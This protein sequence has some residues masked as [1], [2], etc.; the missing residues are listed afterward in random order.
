[1]KYAVFTSSIGNI[2]MA[3]SKHII[4]VIAVFAMTSVF[5]HLNAQQTALSPVLTDY[6]NLKDALV[7]SDSKAAAEKAATLVKEINSVDMGAIPAKDH[8]AFM[9]LKDK[10]AFDARHI[11]ESTDLAHQREH[12]AALS[13]NMASLAKK[14]KLSEQPVYEEYCPMKKASW[15]SNETAIK[16]PY[17]G[18]SMLTCGNVKATLKP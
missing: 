6:Y 11:A 16:N 4:A 8:V 13:A 5:A 18:S 12:F 9:S 15:L 10:L 1:M 17:Y 3:A 14:A 7:G 2:F